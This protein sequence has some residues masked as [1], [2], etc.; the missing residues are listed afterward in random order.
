MDTEISAWCSTSLVWFHQVGFSLALWM[1][2]I[3]IESLANGWIAAGLRSEI[4][5]H[6]E[7]LKLDEVSIVQIGSLIS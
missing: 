2:V 1:L 3:R 5:L 4:L 6:N 7:R